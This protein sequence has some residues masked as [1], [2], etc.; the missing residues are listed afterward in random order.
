MMTNSSGAS[1]ISMC[2]K[3]LP[4]AIMHH[5]WRRVTRT[6]LALWDQTGIGGAKWQH[7]KMLMMMDRAGC[8][9]PLKQEISSAVIGQFICPPLSPPRCLQS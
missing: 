8:H 3:N 6:P 5:L 7:A 9:F 4:K 1:I 2:Q